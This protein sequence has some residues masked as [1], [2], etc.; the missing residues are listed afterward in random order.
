MDRELYDFAREKNADIYTRGSEGY[1]FLEEDEKW[2]CIA[3]PNHSEDL[4][5]RCSKDANLLCFDQWK[6]TFPNDPQG[7]TSLMEQAENIMDDRSYIW[8]ATIGSKQFISLVNDDPG[9]FYEM[10]REGLNSE[11]HRLLFHADISDFEQSFVFW[12][13]MMMEPEKTYFMN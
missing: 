11:I 4:M 6:Q 8:K 7:I 10:A 5:I 13:P 3:N 12:D 2:I 1:D 9:I